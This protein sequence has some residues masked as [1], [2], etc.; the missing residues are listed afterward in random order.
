MGRGKDER[1]APHAETAEPGVTGEIW[2]KHV[3]VCTGGDWC[4]KE[5]GDGLGV[6]A[7]LKKAVAQAGLKGRVR[8]NHAGCL[9]QCGY[10]PMVV[11]YPDAVWYW[12]VRPEDVEQIV[13]EHLIAG[14]PVE[15]LRYQNTPGKN[16]L[17]R[18]A[19]GRPVG[20][21]VCSKER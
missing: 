17:S 5:D 4:L 15:R 10:G 11:V 20:R 6:H 16:K 12:G 21:P 9:D 2:E 18:D 1:K 14:R 7:R 8:V 19:K 13:Q 3:F